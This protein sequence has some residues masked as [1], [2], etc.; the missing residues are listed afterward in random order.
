MKTLRELL[1]IVLMGATLVATAPTAPAQEAQQ[2]NLFASEID[3]IVAPIAL[4]PTR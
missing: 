2:A 4:T 1:A 3:N